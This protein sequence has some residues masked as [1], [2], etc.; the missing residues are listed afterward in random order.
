MRK[1]LYLVIIA[2][3]CLIPGCF[4]FDTIPLHSEQQSGEQLQPEAGL[5]GAHNAKLNSIGCVY[6][7]DVIKI[8]KGADFETVSTLIKEERCFVIPTNTDVFIKERIQDDIVSVKL[9]DS[10]QLFYTVRSNL[11]MK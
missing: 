2:A 10:K 8:T 3:S 1:F 4:G 5:Q 11:I 9:R 6:L 7:S